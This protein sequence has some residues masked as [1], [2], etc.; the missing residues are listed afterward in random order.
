VEIQDEPTDATRSIFAMRESLVEYN[1]DAGVIVAGSDGLLESVL[2][3]ATQS[4]S[5]GDW[6]LG[7][8]IHF[9]PTTG[10]AGAG[11]VLWS[12]LVDQRLAG[13]LVHGGNL[14]MDQT[15]VSFSVPTEAYGLFGDGLAMASELGPSSAVVTNSRVADNARAGIAVFGSYLQLGGSQLACNAFDLTGEPYAGSDYVLED[16]GSNT[17]GCGDDKHRCA[18]VSSGLQAPPSP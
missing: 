17:C 13:V 14:V 15:A 12:A 5:I 11:T 9:D 6:G 8:A 18:A 7:L 3:R 4:D 2:I 16:I 10:Q 1:H